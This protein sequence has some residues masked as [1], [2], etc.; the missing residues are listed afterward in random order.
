MWILSLDKMSLGT[1]TTSAINC[2]GGNKS[3]EIE[4]IYFRICF[5]GNE[6]KFESS[7][8]DWKPKCKDAT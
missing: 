7:P 1:R 4:A 5:T 2:C 6:N 3:P 8:K